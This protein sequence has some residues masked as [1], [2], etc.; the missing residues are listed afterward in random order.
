MCRRNSRKVYILQQIILFIFTH[1]QDVVDNDDYDD[2][3]NNDDAYNDHCLNDFYYDV[4]PIILLDFKI[5]NLLVQY[6]AGDI[7]K[8]DFC[9]CM[10][11][12]Q[13]LKNNV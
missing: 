10:D 6:C 2:N 4:S 8:D 1:L 13:D 12:H 7:N 5:D 11:H 9:I 3:D